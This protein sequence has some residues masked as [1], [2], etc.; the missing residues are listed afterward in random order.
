MQL[1]ELIM[2]LIVIMQVK[3]QINCGVIIVKKGVIQLMSVE[4]AYIM[5]REEQM[6]M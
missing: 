3:E 5:N 6:L 2:L 1:P 4:N